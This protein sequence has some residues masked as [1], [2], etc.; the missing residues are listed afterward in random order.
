[1]SQIVISY[2][3]EGVARARSLAAMLTARGW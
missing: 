3:K 2:A 1:M